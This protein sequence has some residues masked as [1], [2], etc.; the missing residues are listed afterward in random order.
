VVAV[1]QARPANVVVVSLMRY[2]P[3]WFWFAIGSA[4]V[5]FLQ[6]KGTGPF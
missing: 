4:A 2:P 6:V 5:L 1:L 3:M